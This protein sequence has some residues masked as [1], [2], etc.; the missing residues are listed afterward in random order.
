MTVNP[1]MIVVY[2]MGDTQLEPIKV[3][4]DYTSISYNPKFDDVGTFTL[5]MPFSKDYFKLFLPSGNLEKVILIEEGIVGI[6][7]KISC[8][9]KDKSEVLKIQG[10][11]GEAFL[12]NA[13]IG[14]YDYHVP[15]VQ[16]GEP[17]YTIQEHIQ[18]AIG[19]ST[20]TSN[21][22]WD[23]MQFNTIPVDES[24][25]PKNDV[26]AGISTLGEFI[27]T[28]CKSCNKGYKVRLNSQTRKLEF[29]L[30]DYENHGLTSSSPVIISRD[31]MP[32][33]STKFSINTQAYK[34]HLMVWTEYDIN[35]TYNQHLVTYT[36]I[37]YYEPDKIPQT[38][39]EIRADYLKIDISSEDPITTMTEA[40][41]RLKANG[42]KALYDYSY[43]KSY[44]C[45]LST[46]GQESIYKFG[47]DYYIGDI[48]CVKDP[49]MDLTL[50]VRLL[51]YTMT[52]NTSGKY[53]DPTFGV[54]QPTLNAV[55]KK[56]KII[57]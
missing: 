30:C 29:S 40:Y 32:V 18:Y 46:E 54:S 10:S 1:P 24:F 28:L 9:L 14:H 17:L 50:D 56:Q 49:K 38:K 53:F 48:L 6:C 11:L 7:Q 27:R 39:K 25:I 31:F 12:D 43:V 16:E 35:D 44:E 21:T 45:N 57:V 37:D 20:I 51:E 15:E 4:Q 13:I 41:N 34:N 55:L 26:M 52:Y 23:A 19:D 8:D 33:S 36:S 42:K 5:T 2:N 3:V 22:L 47:E